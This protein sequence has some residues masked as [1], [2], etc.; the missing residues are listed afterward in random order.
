MSFVEMV[1][2]FSA[3]R[4][5]KA[6]KA[7]IID[8]KNAMLRVIL[9]FLKFCLFLLLWSMQNKAFIYTF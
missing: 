8:R 9:F 2:T 3:A 6:E 1:T 5:T 4:D 7:K